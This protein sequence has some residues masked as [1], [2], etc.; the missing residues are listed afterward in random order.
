MD[1]PPDEA[2]ADGAGLVG[3]LIAGWLPG[4]MLAGAAFLVSSLAR[5]MDS[6]LREIG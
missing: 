3:T 1:N 5:R 4:C 2:F 6:R